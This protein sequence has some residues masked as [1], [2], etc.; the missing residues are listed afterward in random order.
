MPMKNIK[1]IL[2]APLTGLLIPFSAVSCNVQKQPK[3]DSQT[4]KVD[5]NQNQKIE[6]TNKD[7]QEHKEIKKFISI[8]QNLFA[9]SK[10]INTEFKNLIESYEQKIN[11]L[12]DKLDANKP[13]SELN[14]T[15][16]DI[17]NETIKINSKLQEYND[18]QKNIEQL[19]YVFTNLQLERARINNYHQDSNIRTFVD[20]EVSKINNDVSTISHL[21]Q[22]SKINTLISK[23]NLKKQELTQISNEYLQRWNLLHSIDK[24][25]EQYNANAKSISNLD[26][27]QSTQDKETFLNINKIIN[28]ARKLL[29]WKSPTFELDNLF[30][31]A[32][33]NYEIQINKL[34]NTLNSLL[35]KYVKKLGSDYQNIRRKLDERFYKLSNDQNNTFKKYL[36]APL[37]I[38]NVSD[39]N[40][41]IDIYKQ[42]DKLVKF[43]LKHISLL[44]N[45]MTKLEKIKEAKERVAE[46]KLYHPKKFLASGIIKDAHEV[47]N[48]I[49][50]DLNNNDDSQPKEINLKL[51]Q[52]SSLWKKIILLSQEMDEFLFDYENNIFYPP[53]N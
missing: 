35:D 34:K 38:N 29:T 31:F 11:D 53:I 52:D 8:Y 10:N 41:L 7:N 51:M 1:K 26:F 2:T 45:F 5:K 33:K 4:S 24:I 6:H 28:D 12:K 22:K 43:A 13:L 50:K 47:I 20:E 46:F 3:Q 39:F 44:N 15:K 49:N 16:N 14:A 37:K 30:V 25:I 42:K 21:S 32:S 27:Y 40:Y 9:N 48:N 36:E 19:H 18:K 17:V 23:I